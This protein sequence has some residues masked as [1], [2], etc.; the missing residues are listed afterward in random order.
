RVLPR[1]YV[2]PRVRVGGARETVLG[3]MGFETDFGQRAWLEDAARPT[4][5]QPVEVENGPGAVT[6]RRQGNGYVISADL[7][8]RAYVV[9]SITAWRGWRASSAGRPLPLAYANHAFVAFD[10]PAGRHE[11]RLTYLPGA[12]VWGRRISLVTL[13]LIAA[14]AIA[15]RY[16]SRVASIASP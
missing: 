7:T 12:F 11:V 13:A 3:E 9:T 16:R 14:W 8:G 6:T 1:A 5:E 10:L 4:G 2:P 15:R